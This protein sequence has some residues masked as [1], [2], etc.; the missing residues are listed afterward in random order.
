MDILKELFSL[1]ELKYKEFHKKLIPNVDED[2]IIGVRTP[3]VKKLT[4]R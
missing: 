4:K 1:K 2:L 3:S